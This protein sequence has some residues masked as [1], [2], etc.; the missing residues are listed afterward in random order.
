MVRLWVKHFGSELDNT[1]KFQF[2]NGTIMS[3]GIL[4]K[5]D[6]TFNFNSKMVRLW[7][8]INYAAQLRFSYFNSKMVRLWVNGSTDYAESFTLFQFQ[9]GTIMSP[10]EIADKFGFGYFNSKMVR[11]WVC[12][13]LE[14][15]ISYVYFNSKMVRLWEA[16]AALD[17]EREANFNSK[18]VRLWVSS[19]LMSFKCLNLFQFQNG[20]IMR[21]NAKPLKNAL[22]K[23][24]FQNG[25]IMREKPNAKSPIIPISIPKWYDYE[26]QI[27]LE[28]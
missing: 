16:K 20:T 22:L 5:L 26:V 24:Q 2:Q 11:L 10:D 15:L 27:N 14:N 7:G 8:T 18:M 4:F 13:E 21:K 9:N 1:Y 19:R 28:W 12:P 25:T 6:Q 17:K 3:D 23:F